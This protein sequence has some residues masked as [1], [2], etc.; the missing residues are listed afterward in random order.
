MERN[1]VKLSIIIPAYNAEPYIHELVDCLA[2]QLNDEVEVIIVDDG[3][4]NAFVLNPKYSDKPFKVIRKENGGVSSARN[5]GIENSCGKYLSFI[6]ADDL[7]A[8]SFVRQIF[9]KMPFDYLEMSWKSLPGGPQY[10]KK[11]NSDKD[12]LLNPSACTRVFNRAFVGDVRFNEN[13]DSAEDE[14]F[15]R[16]L[17]FE[18]GKRVVITDYMYFYRTNVENSG[19][20]R[21]MRGETRTKRIIYYYDHISEDMSWLI[22]EVKKEDECNEVII[23]T[24]Q[25]DIPE[26]RKYAQIIKPERVRGMELRGE[27]TVLFTK[28]NVPIKA[29]V[30]IWTENTYAAGGIETFT[31]NFCSQMHNHYDIVVLYKTINDKQKER[32]QKIVRVEQTDGKTPVYCDTLIM[33]RIIDTV[34]SNITY[35]QIVQM[36]HTCK[37]KPEYHVPKDRDKI[38]FVSETAKESFGDEGYV[39]NNMTSGEPATSPLL[40]VTA[41]RLDTSEKGQKRMLKLAELLNKAD[42]P[43]VWLYFSNARLNGTPPNMIHMQPSIDI[44]GYIQKADYLV[45]LSDS[46]SFC[47]SIVEALEL[48]VPVITTSLPVLSE[49]GVNENNA[50]ILPFDLSDEYDVT[51]IY[52]DR[53]KQFKYFYNNDVLRNKW[54]DVLDNIEPEQFVKVIVTTTYHDNRLNETLEKGTELEMEKRRALHVQEV[55]YL[56]ILD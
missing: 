27:K 54:F 21:A 9:E 17:D 38:V 20:K 4:K 42:I 35:K 23:M 7:V 36:C 49:I 28:I 25:N 8:D 2:P 47:F 39:I 18:H 52:S 30:V 53:K 45:Q 55:G 3:S 56:K 6:D 44:R 14:D 10:F 46:E 41:S 31:Y 15:T 40:L 51:P 24:N 26:L 43:F 48:G 37:I 34:P 33:N 11:L 50:H 32:L 1:T 29:Q 5:V 12:R 19:S 16:R 13:K 22:D